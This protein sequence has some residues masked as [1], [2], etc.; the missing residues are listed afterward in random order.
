M[1]VTMS[2]A[3]SPE[4]LKA[5]DEF[6]SSPAEA[7]IQ[8]PEFKRSRIIEQA[9]LEFLERRLESRR[10]KARNARDLEILNHR[11]DE[12]N[13]EVADVLAYQAEW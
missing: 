8:N 7:G 6:G 3:L 4:T 9:V 10:R 1:K 13:R 12:L 11:A 5:I 2:V